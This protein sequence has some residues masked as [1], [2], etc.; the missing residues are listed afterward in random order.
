MAYDE[1]LAERVR[2]VL[3]QKRVLFEEKKMMGGLCYLVDEKMLMGLLT[4]KSTQRPHLMVRVGENAYPIAL[5]KKHASEMNYT[6]RSMKGFV[7]VDE[8]GIDLQND[9]EEW[10]QM[11]LDYNPLAK[12]SK[13]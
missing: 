6:G 2:Q 13:K 8:A 9:L 12:K 3:Q 7:F 5:N 10:V 1:N 11:C 4:D